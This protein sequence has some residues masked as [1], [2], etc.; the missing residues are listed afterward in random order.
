M[1]T[2]T[3]VTTDLSRWWKAVDPNSSLTE[4]G[5]TNSAGNKIL[6]SGRGLVYLS[7]LG[8]GLS[9]RSID[10]DVWARI[11]W[12]GG[13]NLNATIATTITGGPWS[14]GSNQVKLVTGYGEIH[15][16]DR[17]VFAGHGAEYVITSLPG[18]PEVFISPNLTSGVATSEN[19]TVYVCYQDAGPAIFDKTTAGNERCIYVANSKGQLRVYVYIGSPSPAYY[20]IKYNESGNLRSNARWTP[21]AMDW[22]V[23]YQFEWKLR[24]NRYL[25]LYQNGVLLSFTADSMGTPITTVDIQNFRYGPSDTV[26]SPLAQGF[27]VGY[28]SAFFNKTYNPGADYGYRHTFMDELRKAQ[29]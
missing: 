9:D 26:Y 16:G 20:Q 8:N 11:G 13:Y 15:P 4:M 14:A 23:A 25:Q 7:D 29:L 24:Q 21:N 1:S 22:R 3:Y 12:D 19:A 5:F 17:I 10:M 28:G 2:R 18:S 27:A 6:Q